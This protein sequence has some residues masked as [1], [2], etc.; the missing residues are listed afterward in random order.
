MYK[1]VIKYMNVLFR[2]EGS[3]ELTSNFDFN[4]RELG[5]TIVQPINKVFVFVR[6]IIGFLDSLLR[7]I[8]IVVLGDGHGKE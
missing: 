3:V 1:Y 7:V 6:I 2:F 8:I 4:F 5:L